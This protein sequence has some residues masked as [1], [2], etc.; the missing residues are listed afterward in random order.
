MSAKYDLSILIPARN[1]MF[2]GK[3]IENIFENIEGA[4]EV[5]AVLDGYKPDPVLQPDP[6][7]TLI[8]N[9]QSIGQRAATNQAC[10]ISRA[11]YVMKIDAHCAFDKGFDVKMIA[12]MKDDWTMAPLMKNLHAFDWVCPDGHRRYQGPSGPCQ[13]CGK[14][15]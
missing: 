2:L 3:T 5:I 4:T 15:T 13:V 7:V 6:R 8:Y 11:K 10:K 12:E 1:E 14:E 9:S